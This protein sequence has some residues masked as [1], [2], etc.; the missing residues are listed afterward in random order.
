AVGPYD[1][2]RLPVATL[3]ARV[4][5]GLA[6]AQLEALAI[7]LG[8]GGRLA[9]RGTLERA[10]IELDLEAHALDLAALHGRLRRTALD[11]PLRARVE[12]ER[13][14]LTARLTGHGTEL[15]FTAERRGER[16]AVREL[17][18]RAGGGELTGQGEIALG[19]KQAFRA[20]L[21]FERFDPSAWGDF[22]GGA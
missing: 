14:L 21:A 19:D 5:T 16:L 1:G 6:H 2:G 18:A 17:R 4:T 12:R 22:P 7:G 9:G 15:A 10:G 13:Q 8:R 20:E 11:R 3:D